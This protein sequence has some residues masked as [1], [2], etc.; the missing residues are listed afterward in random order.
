M[1]DSRFRFAEW[2]RLSNPG[3]VPVYAELQISTGILTI[4]MSGALMLTDPVAFTPWTI[5]AALTIWVIDAARAQGS[6]V[7]IGCHA[8]TPAMG[9]VVTYA[10]PPWTLQGFGH[11]PVAPFADF[12]IVT[13]P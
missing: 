6:Q 4:T 10:P 7:M 8:S 13:I 2:A 9:D 12:P 5:H 1:V 3:P 11:A